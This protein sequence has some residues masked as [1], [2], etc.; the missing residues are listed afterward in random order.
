MGDHMDLTDARDALFH[1]G[2]SRPDAKDARPVAGDDDVQIGWTYSVSQGREY[3][4]VLCDGRN[5]A[6]T[7]PYRSYAEDAARIAVRPSMLP[8]RATPPAPPA[9]TRD[10]DRH[11]SADTIAAI[12]ASVPAST[13]RAYAADR[14]AYAAWCTEQGRTP[15]PATGETMAEYV[16]HLTTTPRP[17]TGRPASPATIERALS[18]ITTWHEETGQ[19]R[20]VMRGA[21]AVLNAHK[22]HLALTAD[23]AARSQQASAAT[24]Q[25]LRAMLAATNRETL[26][27]KRNAALIL[28]GFATA[29]RVAE[30]TAAD[31]EDITEADHG[32]D[33][34]LY[35]G[36]VRKHTT[37]ALL[38][39]TDPATCPVRTLRTYLTALETEER[40]EGPL[41]VRV[42]RWDRLAP[43]MTRHG[44]P[45]GDPAGRLTAE[46]AADV[47][48][49]LA[50]AAQLTGD[51]SGHS[52]RRGFATAARAAGHDPL[53][54]ARQGGWADGSRTLARYMEDVDRVTKSPLIGIGL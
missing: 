20:P 38:Y 37:T 17:R 51:W 39:G 45:I 16:Q 10:R 12:T 21:R 3:G 42:D 36:K 15:L 33:I 54:I 30:L 13:Q 35:R 47:V 31:L 2:R 27:G 25:Q 6:S 32:Y 9:T 26:A 44:K 23:P 41:F 11:L 46:A 28:L 22:D 29:A 7:E 24:P 53:E 34:H 1:A 4:W 49:R 5:S 43:P 8:V 50:D 52:L 48:E 19:A 40:A 18:A 14:Q